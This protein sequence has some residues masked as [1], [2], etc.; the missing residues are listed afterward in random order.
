VEATD[1]TAGEFQLE[2]NDGTTYKLRTPNGDPRQADA[3]TDALE[4]RLKY[5]SKTARAKAASARAAEKSDSHGAGKGGK[6]GGRHRGRIASED[7]EEENQRTVSNGHGGRGAAAGAFAAG[8]GVA[9]GRTAALELEEE[10]DTM[11]AKRSHK[12][13]E[14]RRG[15]AGADSDDGDGGGGAGRGKTGKGRRGRGG[16]DDEDGSD[17]GGRGGKRPAA[18]DPDSDNNDDVGRQPSGKKPT[19]GAATSKANISATKDGEDED[20]GLKGS[21]SFANNRGGRSPSPVRGG[22]LAAVASAP[23][24]GLRSISSRR[25]GAASAPAADSADEEEDGGKGGSRRGRTDAS[26]EEDSA[27][28]GGR[29]RG[30][31]DDDDDDDDGGRGRRGRGGKGRGGPSGPAA[32]SGAPARRGWVYLRPTTRFG[33]EQKWY[34]TLQNGFLILSSDDDSSKSAVSTED[35][36]DIL[37]V[38]PSTSGHKGCF[39]LLS[40]GDKHKRKFRVD[41]DAQATEWMKAIRAA[42]DYKLAKAQAKAEGG[43]SAGKSTKRLSGVNNNGGGGLRA[44][45]SSKRL[46]VG[47]GDA[48]AGRSRSAA[49]NDFRRGLAGAAAGGRRRSVGGSDDEAADSDMDD[50]DDEDEGL[51]PPPRWFANYDRATK[52]KDREAIW[53]EMS[54]KW[55]EGL[56]QGIYDSPGAGGSDGSSSASDAVRTDSDPDH[57]VVISRLEEATTAACA[58]FLERVRECRSRTRPDLLKHLVQMFDLKFLSCLNLLTTGELDHRLTMWSRG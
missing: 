40:K 58:Q 14:A 35:V 8:A 29:R 49:P 19:L 12:A 26:E 34:L 3:W 28:R 31:D 13:F 4:E 57:K 48:T 38:M 51:P 44:A 56:F 47:G 55:F 23:A 52:D 53:M 1:L 43:T 2:F 21:S 46:D 45:A 50:D 6:A 7:E 36:L 10:E 25:G 5:A 32:P 30:G 15:G 18:S 20:S 42:K 17:D 41:D 11:A 16:D 9:A 24:G 37:S 33:R 39:S 22:G 54:V 27:P